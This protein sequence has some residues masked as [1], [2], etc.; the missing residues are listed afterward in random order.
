[1]AAVKYVVAKGR[2]IH[3]LDAQGNRIV[4]QEGQSIDRL[5]WSQTTID[6]SV[7]SGFVRR[8]D[9]PDVPPATMQ[10]LGPDGRVAIVPT[11]D[12]TAVQEREKSAPAESAPVEPAPAGTGPFNLDPAGLAGKSLDELKLMIAERDARIEVAELR[13]VESAV[14]L[15]SANFEPQSRVATR[16]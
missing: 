8:T 7:K 11:K 15:L 6:A 1:M 2:S 5:G 4:L 9:A 16:K 13:D 3:D 10:T 14:A 12:V